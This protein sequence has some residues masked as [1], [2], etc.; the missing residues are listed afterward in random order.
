M[1]E[2]NKYRRNISG[3]GTTKLESTIGVN[4]LPIHY[5]PHCPISYL[6]TKIRPMSM[7][8]ISND[9]MNAILYLSEVNIG[10]HQ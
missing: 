4:S 5:P 3:N 10:A 2:E 7:V 9:E 1:I 6:H 8:L